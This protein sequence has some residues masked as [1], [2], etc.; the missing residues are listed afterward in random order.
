VGV[1]VLEKDLGSPAERRAP[2]VADVEERIAEDRGR[3]REEGGRVAGR[4]EP[5]GRSGRFSASPGKDEHRHGG[6]DEPDG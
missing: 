4:S 2:A 3:K 1:L 6:R 5:P